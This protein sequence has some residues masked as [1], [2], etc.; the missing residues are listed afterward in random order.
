MIYTCNET[1]INSQTE[2]RLNTSVLNTIFTTTNYKN[3]FEVF[4]L[5]VGLSRLRK[6]FA[7]LKF[8]PALFEEIPSFVC[9]VFKIENE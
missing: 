2:Y 6:F 5:K 4:F 7:K 1:R 9:L 3:R 8:S